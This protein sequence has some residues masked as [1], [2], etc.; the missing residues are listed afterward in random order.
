LSSSS[1]SA[2][3][4]DMHCP[5]PAE[6]SSSGDSNASEIESCFD[7]DSEGETDS[8]TNPTAVDTDVEGEDGADVSWITEEDKDCPPE[9]YIIQEEEFDEFEDANADYKDNNIA[10]LDGIE[11]RWNWYVPIL[12]I[13]RILLSNLTNLQVLSICG[14]GSCPG[15]A[16]H[17]SSYSQ[18]L[19]RLDSKST[20]RKRWQKA[21][22]H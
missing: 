2:D 3:P 6:S 8:D 1:P 7:T 5:P 20:S 15:D 13:C 18:G 14:K 17:L 10:L 12:L 22:R 21:Q 9:Y 4:V 19:L 11:V 16:S